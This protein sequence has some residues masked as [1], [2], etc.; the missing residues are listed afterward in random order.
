MSSDKPRGAGLAFTRE[1][2]SYLETGAFSQSFFEG[3]YSLAGLGVKKRRLS[4]ERLGF[5]GTEWDE[6]KI[7]DLALKFFVEHLCS[8]TAT[9]LRYVSDRAR[10]RE[11]EALMVTMFDQFLTECSRKVSP[12]WWNFRTRIKRVMH[13]LVEEGSVVE[14][15]G[16]SP[17]WAPPSSPRSHSLSLD[18][19]RLQVK[20][21]PVLTRKKYNGQHRVSP[22][23]SEKGLKEILSLVFKSVR[24]PVDLNTLSDF[25]CQ[26][27]GL[28]DAVFDSPEVLESEGIPVGGRFFSI[29]ES[30]SQH[31]G[32]AEMRVYVRQVLDRLTHRQRKIFQLIFLEGCS[33]PEACAALGIGK[34]SVYDDL[35]QIQKEMTR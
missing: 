7:H 18:E 33:V 13:K 8:G 29:M 34:S 26:E 15:P 3:L 5:R 32:E 12:I 23:V 22:E 1:F 14:V 27:L 4:P 17:M 2:R 28:R 16:A 35:Q 31:M 21:L 24:N 25:V 10:E 9:R 6:E 19:L 30:V 11:V 20:A